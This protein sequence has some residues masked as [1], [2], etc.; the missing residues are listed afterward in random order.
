[1]S[2]LL[3]SAASA[4]LLVPAAPQIGTGISVGPFGGAVMALDADPDDSERLLASSIEL[5]LLQTT[6]GGQ[7]FGAFGSG[8]P[9]SSFSTFVRDLARDPGDADHLFAAAGQSLYESTDRGQTWSLNGLAPDGDVRGIVSDAAGAVWLVNTNSTLYRSDDGGATWT[10]PFSGSSVT[11]AAFSPSEPGRVYVGTFNGTFRSSDGGVTWSNPSGETTWT[12]ALACDPTTPGVVYLGGCCGTVKKSVD[13]GATWSD[14]NDPS[15]SSV[16]FLAFDPNVAGRLWLA[17]LA[18]L[19]ISD[20]GG[21]TWQNAGASLPASQPILMDLAFA[22][23][24]DRFLGTEGGGVFRASAGASTW[25]QIGVPTVEL[26]DVELTGPGGAR[27]IANFKGLHDSAGPALPLTQNPWYFD[28]GAHTNDVVI[29]PLNPDR[30]LLA[31]VGAFIDNAT[32]RVLTNGGNTVTTPVEIFG[33]GQAT[34]IAVDPFDPTHM[35][36]SFSPAGFGA[37]GLMESSDSGNNWTG[38]AGTSGGQLSRVAID[39]HQPDHWLVASLQGFFLETSNGGGTFT[40]LNG[41]AGSG[42]PQWVGFDPHAAGTVWAFDDV[43]GLYRSTDGGSTWSLRHP[44]GHQRAS[45]EF[46]PTAPGVLWFGDADGDLL[47]SGDGG[48]SFVQVWE[49]PSGSSINGLALDVAVDSLVVAT[50][51]ESAFEVFGANPYLGLG[52]GTVGTGGVEPRHFGS[53]GLPQLGNAGFGLEVAD[54]LAGAVCVVHLGASDLALP[55]AGGV[56]HTGFPT[57]IQAA[58]ATTGAGTFSLATPV[59]ADPALAGIQFFSQA[60]VLDGGAVDGLALS[61]GLA[62]RLLP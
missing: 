37:P 46:H 12:K 50:G 31:G 40:T 44:G 21:A 38:I 36:A 2:L 59:P 34:S 47:L 43:D 33:S 55:F 24:G 15:N 57:V 35:V 62:L 8:L 10:A 16:Q 29:D 30:W 3:A 56:L 18:G 4:L 14:L 26:W 61:D 60:F 32:I 22:T 48:D 54:A 28:F 51:A 53:G 7:S 9:A 41:W 20:N 5:G 6:T 13:G 27:V 25:V 49:S 11:R 58:G 45:V 42:P 23:D 1:M 19:W 52:G 39:P 17:Y